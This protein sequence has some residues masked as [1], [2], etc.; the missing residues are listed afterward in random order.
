MSLIQ[1]PQRELSFSKL[2]IFTFIF[3]GAAAG[4][5]QTD[6]PTSVIQVDAGKVA[7]QMPPTFYG[8]MTEEIN[9][10][11][12][13]GLYGELIRNRAFKAD[14]IQ[15]PVKPDNYDPAK[16]YPVNIAATKAP[17]FWTSVGSAKISLDTNTPL[18]RSTSVSSST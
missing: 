2:A 3:A 14:A 11:Y 10:S 7:A 17:K 9:F 8:L 18:T 12:E 13:G 16:S 4:F 15:Q 5:A 1:S 6:P